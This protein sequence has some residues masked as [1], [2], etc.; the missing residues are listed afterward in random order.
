M[1]FG[2][3]KKGFMDCVNEY[4]INLS[5]DEVAQEPEEVTHK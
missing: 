3:I 4:E 2:K 5:K 1:K